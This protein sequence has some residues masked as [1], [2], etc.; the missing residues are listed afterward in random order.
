MTQPTRELRSWGGRRTGAGRPP[1]GALAGVPHLERAVL[2]PRFPVHAT[3][4]MA[5][6]VW[7]LRTRRSFGALSRAMHAGAARFGV[8]L[9]H[10]AVLGTEVH[11]MVEAPDRRALSR[12]MKG[13]GVRI[14]RALNRVMKRNGPVLADRYHARFLVTPSQARRARNQLLGGAPRRGYGT[15]DAYASIAPL[16]TPRTRLLERLQR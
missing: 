8:R 7:S 4:R 14:A 1:K 13:L 3:W 6:G 5:E 2:A 10:Y 9:V 15:R 12:A 11:L 16:M